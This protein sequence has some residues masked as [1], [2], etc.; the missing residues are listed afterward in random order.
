MSARLRGPGLLTYD[1]D[2]LQAFCTE[3]EA[4]PEAFDTVS[5]TLRATITD[6]LS[7]LL[8]RRLSLKMPSY[9]AVSLVK[10]VTYYLP[11]TN[12]DCDEKQREFVNSCNFFAHCHTTLG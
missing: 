2:V 12:S 1:G 11:L 9:K 8:G 7:D 5:D 3:Q 10:T 6:K 4:L